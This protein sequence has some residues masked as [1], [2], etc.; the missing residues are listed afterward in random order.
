MSQHLISSKLQNIY[1]PSSGVM[2]KVKL[3]RSAGSGK[4]VFIVDGRSS[5]VKSASYDI[6][7]L[8]W[9]HRLRCIPFCTRI[10]AALV[11]G[12]FFAAAS[13]FFFILHILRVKKLLNRIYRSRGYNTLIIVKSKDRESR[14]RQTVVVRV[15]LKCLSDPAFGR[16]IRVLACSFL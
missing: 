12:F 3:R 14:V 5:S 8:C 1:A 6:S 16:V 15:K 7:F 10:W 2:V 4:F 13:S 11:L 9:V